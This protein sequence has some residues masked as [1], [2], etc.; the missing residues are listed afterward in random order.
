MYEMSE[1]DSER[2]VERSGG[3]RGPM[4]RENEGKLKRGATSLR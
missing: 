3:S 2:E 1:R 4:A